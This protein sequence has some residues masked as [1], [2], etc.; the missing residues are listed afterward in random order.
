MD[1]KGQTLEAGSS[2][3]AVTLE[4]L[5]RYLNQDGLFCFLFCP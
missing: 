4:R 5:N 3:V 2:K 1:W